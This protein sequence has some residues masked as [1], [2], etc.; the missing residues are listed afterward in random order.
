MMNRLLWLA[1]LGCLCALLSGCALSGGSAE[2]TTR[3]MLDPATSP[4]QEI[5]LEEI[6][7]LLAKPK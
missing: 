5:L 1:Q 6:R 4:R 3:D 2:R 7:D